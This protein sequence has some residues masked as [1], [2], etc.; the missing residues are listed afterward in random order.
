MAGIFEAPPNEISSP[1]KWNIAER[2]YPHWNLHLLLNRDV[3]VCKQQHKTQYEPQ[4]HAVCRHGVAC[5]DG[6]ITSNCT[7]K[8]KWHITLFVAPPNGKKHRYIFPQIHS[9]PGS[10]FF[11]QINSEVL[12]SHDVVV[13]F[14]CGLS[15]PWATISKLS[16]RSRKSYKVHLRAL[17][18][19]A[20]R[21][22][23]NLL[24][25][26]LAILLRIYNSLI[27][28]RYLHILLHI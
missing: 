11:L 26:A 12:L 19:M 28:M 6:K 16:E 17:S 4:V 14:A 1:T 10:N 27:N 3:E 5:C 9:I 8:F 7:I 23:N 21:S 18:N 25:Y 24:A 20:D 13:V 22:G 15:Y 2:L